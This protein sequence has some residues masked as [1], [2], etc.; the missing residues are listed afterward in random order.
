MRGRLEHKIEM[1]KKLQEKIEEMPEYMKKFYMSLNQ[2]SHTTKKTY[3]NNVVRFLLKTYGEFPS[4]ETLSKVES[5]DIQMYIAEIN[6]YDDSNGQIQELKES[7]QAAIYS[8]IAMFF[9]FLNRIYKINNNPFENKMIERPTIPDKPVSYLEID[10]V[11]RIESQILAGAGNDLSI[12]K[13]KDWKYRDVLLF[14]LPLINGVRLSAMDEINIDDIDMDHRK[15]KVTEKRNITK[16]IDFDLKTQNY[17]Q[18]WLKK[19]KELLGDNTEEK[20]L[21]ISNRRTRMT[22]RAIEKVIDKYG[23]AA[24]GKHVVPHDL[25]RTCGT[26]TY[27]ETGDIYLVANILGHKTAAPTRRY[28]SVSETSRRD[29]INMMANK[30]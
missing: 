15:I 19:R 20:S 30:Y 28:A 29:T 24:I 26:Q 17:L 12:S 23:M 27:R 25:R 16:M 9:V 22:N 7:T 1:E 21:F 6:F 13:Q 2:K 8:S 5:Y 18:I 14:R 10:E 3:L 4:I 11:K